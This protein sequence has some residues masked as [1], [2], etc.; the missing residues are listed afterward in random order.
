MK[1]TDIK[2]SKAKFYLKHPATEDA[3]LNDEG[4]EVFWYVVGQDSVEF[5]TAQ[6]GFL[7]HL[8]ELGEDASK[9]TK[10]DYQAQAVKQLSAMVKGWDKEFEDCCGKYS[11]KA[12]MSLIGHEDRR[13]LMKQLDTF[14][15][16]RNHFFPA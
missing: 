9:L 15:G 12:V 3:I 13:W 2:P 16:K 4:T 7:K 5:A 10:D 14:V 8:E 6:Q 11:N 1:L